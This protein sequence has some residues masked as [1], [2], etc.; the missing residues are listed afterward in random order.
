MS[1]PEMGFGIGRAYPTR[2]AILA[3][4][5]LV[6]EQPVLPYL[7]E[8]IAGWSVTAR[9]NGE[10][11][12]KFDQALFAKMATMARPPQSPAAPGWDVRCPVAILRAEH[13][14]MSPDMAGWLRGRLGQAAFVAEIPA[15]GH[16]VLLDEPLSLVTALRT[17]LASWTA[18]EPRGRTTAADDA[19]ADDARE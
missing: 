1:T 14:L 13:G 5:R 9:E 2:E 11:G 12:W 16:H 15:A 4:F 10:W 6:P 8:H 19:A 3:R 17:V 18:P 7:R